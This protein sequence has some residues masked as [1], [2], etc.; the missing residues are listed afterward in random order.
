M[1]EWFLSG[2]R[3][4]CLSTS[5]ASEIPRAEF[6][7]FQLFLSIGQDGRDGS[8]EYLASPSEIVMTCCAL[9]GMDCVHNKCI[10][11]GFTY[12]HTYMFT[13]WSSV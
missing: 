4:Y 2:L 1:Q 11:L 7:H 6:R 3:S 12:I 13:L 9:D 10:V 5:V 8:R